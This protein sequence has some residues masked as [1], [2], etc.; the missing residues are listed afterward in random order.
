M[1]RLRDT[2]QSDTQHILGLLVEIVQ[3]AKQTL[4]STDE[5][6]LKTFV[7]T[8]CQILCDILCKKD[9]DETASIGEGAILRYH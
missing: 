6:L 8:E 3:Q 1:H 9:V 2:G 5:Q 4:S 7:L